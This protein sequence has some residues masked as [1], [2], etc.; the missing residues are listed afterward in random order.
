MTRALGQVARILTVAGIVAKAAPTH[1]EA[2]FVA[3]ATTA[4][5]EASIANVGSVDSTE[6]GAH[7][8][9]GVRRS[10]EKGDFGVRVELDD[11]DDTFLAVRAID[12][13]FHVSER[14]AV[15]A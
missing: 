13:R 11:L 5:I 8:G 4:R 12:Y 1:A 10:L 15:S 3:G 2:F 6:T 9:F 7:L 14:L